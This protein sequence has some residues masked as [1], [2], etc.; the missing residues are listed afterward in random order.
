MQRSPSWKSDVHIAA[1]KYPAIFN[2]EE[3][4]PKLGIYYKPLAK[5]K[6]VAQRTV[7]RTNLG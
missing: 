4:L 3:K 6:E 5:E 1:Q 2:A 7:E